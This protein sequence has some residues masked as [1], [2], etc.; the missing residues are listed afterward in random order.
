MTKERPIIFSGPMVRAIIEGR[1]TQ[2]RRVVKNQGSLDFLGG[3]GDD[4]NDP[5]MWGWRVDGNGRD[6]FVP[7]AKSEWYDS[8]AR[9]PYGVPGDTLWVREG[10]S[11]DH[12]AFY[13]HWGLVYRAD[14]TVLDSDIENGQ[15]FSHEA[16][17]SFPF[18]W[19]P[20]IHMPRW[21]CRLTL[22]VKAVRVERLQDISEADAIAEGCCTRTYRDGRGHEDARL[23]FKRLWDSING[24]RHPWASNPWVWVV[25]FEPT[26]KE[27]P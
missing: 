9:C 20:S 13:P 16:G 17:K 6:E 24:K 25:E 10:F 5:S 21:A 23:D 8:C 14:R 1:K 22:A 18:R 19:R 4:R 2:T 7:L 27:K 12:R 3:S 11:T 15:V 26:S